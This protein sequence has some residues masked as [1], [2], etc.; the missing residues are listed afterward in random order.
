M[1]KGIRRRGVLSVETKRGI[2]GGE[3]WGGGKGD[4][5][6]RNKGRRTS[7]CER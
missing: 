5:I 7:G 1:W 3:S 6:E 4:I 2:S